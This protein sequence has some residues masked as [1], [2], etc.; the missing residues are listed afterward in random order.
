M[1]I[2][3]ETELIEALDESRLRLDQLKMTIEVGKF[4][5]KLW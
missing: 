3:A 4:E 1:L 2:E 5:S